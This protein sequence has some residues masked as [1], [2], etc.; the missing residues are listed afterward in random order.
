MSPY[1]NNTYINNAYSDL[2]IKNSYTK[3]KWAI[4]I[5]KALGFNLSDL[6]IRL[7]FETIEDILYDNDIIS[8]IDSKLEYFIHKFNIAFPKKKVSEMDTK[9]KLKFISK[10]IESQYGL[11]IT[12]DSGKNYYLSDN[13]KWDELYEYRN[14]VSASGKKL[15]D[16]ILKKQKEN[17]N[18]DQSW[19]EE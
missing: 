8:D 3:H 10:I 4:Q 17:I 16:K 5:I 13:N 19:F 9:D 11:T 14:N 7:T 15:N 1:F 2:T 6:E 12:K 18:I